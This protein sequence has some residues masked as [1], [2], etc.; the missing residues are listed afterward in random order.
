MRYVGPILTSSR[1]C[2]LRS[3]CVVVKVMACIG[4]EVSADSGFSLAVPARVPWVPAAAANCHN[5]D[6]LADS[7]GDDILRV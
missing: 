4:L 5:V 3:D 1:Q 7:E 2:T 6:N